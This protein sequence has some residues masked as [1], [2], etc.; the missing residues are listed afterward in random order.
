MSPDH[1]D[2]NPDFGA[3]DGAGDLDLVIFPCSPYGPML[4]CENIER[5]EDHAREEN[6]VVSIWTRP[7]NPGS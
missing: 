1:A 7:D 4:T 5:P 3:V 6:V 2:L